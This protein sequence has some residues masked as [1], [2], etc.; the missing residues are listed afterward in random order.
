LIPLVI[1][2]THIVKLVK[3]LTRVTLLQS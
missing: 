2:H 3:C 1:A